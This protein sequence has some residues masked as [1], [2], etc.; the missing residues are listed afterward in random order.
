MA[1]RDEMRIR[2]STEGSEID[3]YIITSYDE[4]L[5]EDVSDSD[6]R[7]HYI[8]GFTGKKADL[9]VCIHVSIALPNQIGVII[10]SILFLFA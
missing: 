8:S 9:A 4:H 7:S 2:A 10:V 6:K 5:N 1:L 3:A